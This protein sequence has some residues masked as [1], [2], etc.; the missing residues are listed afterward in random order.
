MHPQRFIA[1]AVALLLL[2]AA[3]SKAELRFAPLATVIP[4]ATSSSTPVEACETNPFDSFVCYGPT[5]V[6]SAYGLNNLINSG[7]DGT[8][9]TI[10][11]LNAYGSP[12]AADDL[13]GFDARFGL[14]NPPSFN[15][16]KMPGTPDFDVSNGSMLGWALETSLDVQ[17]AHAIAPN[18]KIV[19]VEAASNTAG[20]L[21]TALNYAIDR[22][23]GDVISLSF[24]VSE[25]SLT[26][27]DGQAAVQA[28]E[29]AFKRARRSRITI[30]AAAGDSGSTNVADDLG[31]VF[32]APN[33]NY[34][35]S[36]PNVL[37]VGGTS[38]RVGIGGSADPNGAYIGETVW[39]GTPNMVVGGGG[40]ISTLFRRPDYQDDLPSQTRRMLG[41][42]R[43]VP[44]VAFGADPLS[45]F[46]VYVGG[47]GIVDPSD[48][49]TTIGGKI[50]RASCRERV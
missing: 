25:L 22:R 32:S 50:G 36:S 49:V 38:L 13:K 11:I 37:S 30:V 8:R 2:S 42:H 47:L 9:Q 15:V 20:D 35:A 40:G 4:A 43:G 21:L 12:S 7:L 10:V 29:Q 31:N 27:A 26:T 44:D 41:N 34:P 14:P 23:L 39:N 28:W 24:G 5:A 19:L 1:L 16:V 3:P 17:W 46:L 18:A 33:V 48:P 45:G 6:R